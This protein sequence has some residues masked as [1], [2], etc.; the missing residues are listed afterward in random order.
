VAR[1]GEPGG[2]IHDLARGRDGRP[3]RPRQPIERLR[4]EAQLEPPVEE[5]EPLRFILRRLCGALCAQLAAR[6]AGAGLAVLELDLEASPTVRMEQALP[7]PTAAADLLERLLLARLTAQPPGAPVAGVALQL[8]R[9]APAP[10]QQLGLFTPQ[11][12]RAARLDW[13]LAGLA[14]RYGADR[15]WRTRV[16]DPEAPLAE[17]RVEW[18]RATSAPMSQ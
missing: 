1:F 7:E 5:I 17:Q 13:Q 15:L 9:A 10:G 14:L 6:G 4:A 2:V 8:E 3:L 18:Q 11:L 16:L 12:A